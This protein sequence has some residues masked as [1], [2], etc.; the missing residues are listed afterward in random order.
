MSIIERALNKAKD[1]R[2]KSGGPIGFPN[3]IEKSVSG[4]DN[5][6]LDTPMPKGMLLGVTEKEKPLHNTKEIENINW[7]KLAELGFVTPASNTDSQAI[8]EYRNIKRPLINNAFGVGSVGINRSNLILVTSS[9]PGEGK[10]FTAINLALS[11]ANERDKKVLLIDADVARPS[12]SS[13]LGIKSTPGL[14]EYL[15][16]QNVKFS[17]IVLKT[18]M[19]GLNIIPSGKL[20]KHSTELLTS[21]RMIQLAQELSNRYPDRMVIFDSPPLLA[22]TQGEV[23]AG[24]VGQVVLVVEAEKTPQSMIMA[25][26]NKL[27]FCDVVLLLLNKTQKNEDASYYGYG[28]YGH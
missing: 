26:V 27:V 3:E 20:H 4:L 19:P 6:S 24:L 17:D 2:H 21:N 14:I 5:S 9:I 12:I 28:L 15:E 8:E 7:D 23:L 10:T 16:G 11:I 13:V 22:A 18:N 1:E 25:S